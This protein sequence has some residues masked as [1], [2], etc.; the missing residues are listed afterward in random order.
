MAIF[1]SKLTQKT[2]LTTSQQQALF[3]VKAVANLTGSDS[4]IA[5]TGKLASGSS[6]TATKYEN[7]T[8]VLDN[9]MTLTNNGL[10][11]V[12]AL[13]DGVNGEATGT[14]STTHHVFLV[15]NSKKANWKLNTSFSNSK[16][17]YGAYARNLHLGVSY[18]E[19]FR[20]NL[21]VS[22]KA[23]GAAEVHGYFGQSSLEIAGRLTGTTSVTLNASNSGGHSVS[24]IASNYLV[25]VSE[26]AGAL[27]VKSV[28][29]QKSASVSDVTSWTYGIAGKTVN[30]DKLTSAITVNAYAYGYSSESDALK[31]IAAGINATDNASI[32]GWNG[33][34]TVKSD[35]LNGFNT[36]GINAGGAIDVTS[37]LN[38][39]LNVSATGKSELAMVRADG[40]LAK[41]A[42]HLMGDV[43]GNIAVSTGGKTQM[44]WG[45][46]IR[47]E[48][49]LTIDGDLLG[50]INI[51]CSGG[52]A[53]SY[54]VASS[55][56]GDI[57]IGAVLGNVSIK[58]STEGVACGSFI[59]SNEGT[60]ELGGNL[61]GA[62]TI[63]ASGAFQS[64]VYGVHG[65]T[66][67][68][69]NVTGNQTL[70]LKDSGKNAS[71]SADPSELYWLKAARGDGLTMESIS[72]KLNLSAV[73]NGGEIIAKAIAT[74]ENYALGSGSGIF[75][76]TLSSSATVSATGKG[77]AEAGFVYTKA[78][79]SGI[80]SYDY[81]HVY[82]AEIAGVLKVSAVSKEGAATA[83]A[84]DA[85]NS[86]EVENGVS[87]SQTVSAS[88][89][90]T[91]R[92]FYA[93][94]VYL[95]GETDHSEGAVTFGDLSGAIS[96]SAA[97]SAGTAEADG[98]ISD[99]NLE[100]GN[101]SRNL[102]VSAK[103]ATGVNVLGFSSV[104]DYYS[105]D[106]TVGDIS[107][108]LNFNAAT[109]SGDA[110]LSGF[111][112]GW[113]VVIGNLTG[114]VS[115]T[116]SGVSARAALANCQNLVNFKDITKNVN[117]KATA[118]GNDK[119][120]LTSAAMAV[121]NGLSMVGKLSGNITVSAA[122][123][124]A[125]AAIF[126]CSDNGI[127]LSSAQ[128]TGALTVSATTPKGASARQHIKA[129]AFVSANAG[130]IAGE[131]SSKITASATSNSQFSE[132]LNPGKSPKCYAYAFKSETSTAL[133]A[134]KGAISVTANNTGLSDATA[135]ALYA[136]GDLTVTDTISGKVTVKAT[137]SGK[138]QDSLYGWAMAKFMKSNG[139]IT[140][141]SLTGGM[142]V[143]ASQTG[144]SKAY[145]YGFDAV[146]T[147]K[148]IITVGGVISGTYSVSATTKAV[149]LAYAAVFQAQN[150][151]FGDT[152]AK[153]KFNITSNGSAFGISVTQ[154]ISFAS[155]TSIGNWTVKG[156]DYAGGISA[157]GE[158]R[159]DDLT[160]KITASGDF[161]H[162]VDN[163]SGNNWRV[164]MNLTG[165]SGASAFV[166]DSNASISI[167]KCTINV[168]CA[169]KTEAYAFDAIE[170]SSKNQDIEL[171]AG[172][173]VVGNVDLGTQSASESDKLTLHS[174]SSI[175]GNFSD[176]EVVNFAL[177]DVDY[178]GQTLWNA[179]D[180]SHLGNCDFELDINSGMTGNFA[181]YK[182]AAN[183]V[184]QLFA[185]DSDGKFALNIGGVAQGSLALGVAREID[186]LSYTLEKSKD[187]K[188]LTLAV[189]YAV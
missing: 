117:V 149:H 71:S 177:D 120:T 35:S 1:N 171:L 27:T 182:G 115:A 37:T 22:A 6:S 186:D 113:N 153:A 181:L 92:A 13:V 160:G 168:K 79:V 60:V 142:S 102:T 56:T 8:L 93:D 155:H 49:S 170:A 39:K 111:A 108:N 106:T 14:T 110:Y 166:F 45:C 100:I 179:N 174:G 34:I 184:D 141:G 17:V 137:A 58:A 69:K 78:E 16:S 116:A 87:Q 5:V 156:T 29:S 118:S 147:E 109:K 183:S 175:T 74:S 50:N 84:F 73:N 64:V 121:G 30:I 131:I 162:G 124:N 48:S 23:A 9:A 169:D 164:D 95:K 176:V 185:A 96:V 99:Q 134:L 47:T 82:A 187:G 57:R 70:T 107:G 80:G 133:T 151:I 152:L 25:S 28:E 165:Q 42:I 91:V 136:G 75:F 129:Q 46:A 53:T 135:M 139:N 122:G 125:D 33:D 55:A 101:I 90:T 72:G 65:H 112:A 158:C 52:I 167:G 40:M 7:T 43:A 157:E 94:A 114:T 189:D 10:N 123:A 81:G 140:L 67:N 105:G 85:D 68:L 12:E 86:I 126:R 83:Y 2:V 61:A 138:P 159:G 154:D 21:A 128:L 76:R 41:G 132:P 15:S 163:F 97:S 24:G 44:A 103:G 161:V 59:E 143:S 4:V 31:C 148:G 98:F 144:D 32:S 89:K 127:D 104:S 145:A 172:A 3:T 18:N 54:A 77:A 119:G 66:I 178:A 146:T 20:A 26:L 180:L 62:V 51:S 19:D 63:S 38:G 130:I 36:C 188:S 11:V 173:K 88:G 150:V